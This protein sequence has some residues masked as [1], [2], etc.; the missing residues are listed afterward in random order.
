MA[1]A[2]ALT[3]CSTFQ[4][5]FQVPR[6]Q[7]ALTKRAV[8]ELSELLI[9]DGG[10]FQALCGVQEGFHGERIDQEDQPR[11]EPLALE[12]CDE[13]SLQAFQQARA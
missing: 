7:T 4:Q 10:E 3:P 12:L 6:S 9:I 1:W 13:E 11:E 5:R 8:K 2:F